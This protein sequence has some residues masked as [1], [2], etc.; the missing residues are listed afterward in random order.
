[1]G[2]RHETRALYAWA[3]KADPA[4]SVARE[5]LARLDRADIHRQALARAAA[6][7]PWPDPVPVHHPVRPGQAAGPA[8]A[9]AFTDDAGSAGLR[10]VYDNAETPLHQLPEPFGGGLALLDCDGDGWLDVYCVQGG[11]FV[12]GGTAFQAVGAHGQDA[13]ATVGDRLFH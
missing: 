13:R 2:R 6:V 4:H 12:P 8:G 11:P 5:G 3:L 10:F 9:F 7:E 1:A